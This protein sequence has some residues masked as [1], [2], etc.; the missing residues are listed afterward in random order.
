[1]GVKTNAFLLKIYQH[2]HIP[3]Q[4]R[5]QTCQG[6]QRGFFNIFLKILFF[7]PPQLLDIDSYNLIIQPI[8]SINLTQILNLS[9][10]QYLAK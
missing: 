1:M 5:I 7:I 2:F 9:L 3:Q 8:I 6:Y 10:Q 4:V